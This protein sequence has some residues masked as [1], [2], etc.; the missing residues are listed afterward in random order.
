MDKEKSRFSSRGGSKFFSWFFSKE[1]IPG[2]VVYIVLMV[3][4]LFAIS[5]YNG[6][7]PTLQ[8]VNDWVSVILGSVATVLSV[9][10]MWLSFYSH[11]KARE[12]AIKSTQN[13]SDLRNDMVETLTEMQER[14]QDR[15]YD[16]THEIKGVKKDVEH[17][18]EMAKDDRPG[19]VD[20][21]EVTT[22]FDH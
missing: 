18:K 16:I 14:Q 22:G 15:M 4:V 3:S 12:E 1:V 10:S 5:L 6:D 2:I 7:A 20:K 11:E 21:K 17:L 9:L 8:T 13:I 19:K